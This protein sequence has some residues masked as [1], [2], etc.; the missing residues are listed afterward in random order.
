MLSQLKG[1]AQLIISELA[2]TEEN[3]DI[4]IKLFIENYDDEEQINTKL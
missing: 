2:V 3:Y 4:D 1:T